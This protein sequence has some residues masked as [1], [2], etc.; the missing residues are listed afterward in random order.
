[1]KKETYPPVLTACGMDKEGTLE[2]PSRGGED[3]LD[4]ACGT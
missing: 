4:P 3:Q 1:M 2:T